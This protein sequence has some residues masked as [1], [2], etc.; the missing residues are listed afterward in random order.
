VAHSITPL[1][2]RS[3]PRMPSGAACRT[4]PVALGTAQEQSLILSIV[5]IL[6]EPEQFGSSGLRSPSFSRN[7][8][9]ETLTLLPAA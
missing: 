7:N 6:S 2:N 1:A 4:S 5:T 9:T 3:G 8:T